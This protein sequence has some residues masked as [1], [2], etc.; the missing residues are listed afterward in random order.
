MCVSRS[1]ANAIF[2]LMALKKPML[3]IPLPKGASRGDQVENARLL[4]KKGLAHV[5]LQENLT[6]ETL[7]SGID[8]VFKNKEQLIKNLSNHNTSNANEKIVDILI[9]LANPMS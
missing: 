1:G 5:L 7:A 6:Y 4:E 9:K 3:L 8:N 2:E